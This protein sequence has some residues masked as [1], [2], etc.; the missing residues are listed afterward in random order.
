MRTRLKSTY[1]DLDPNEWLF[2]ETNVSVSPS[3][4]NCQRY[5]FS[6]LKYVPFHWHDLPNMAWNLEAGI[7]TLWHYLTNV[8]ISRC[9][10]R[11]SNR[12]QSDEFELNQNPSCFKGRCGSGSWD[13]IAIGYGLDGPGI[14]HRWGR[15]FPHLSRPALGPTQPPVQWVPGLSRG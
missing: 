10:F 3:D 13:V 14:E 9:W 12:I 15:D 11:A 8:Y 6:I 2:Y 5:I 4:R 1:L 7:M